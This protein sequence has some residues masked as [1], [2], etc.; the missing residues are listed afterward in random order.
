[1]KQAIKILITL[2]S[3]LS[4]TCISFS[5]SQTTF[6]GTYAGELGYSNSN[7]G[8]N[9]GKVIS[10]GNHNA[11]FGKS[12]GEKTTTGYYNSFY[13]AN[14][15]Y[16][17]T[18]GYSNTFLGYS[19]GYY[20]T[21]GI[22]NLFLGSTTG[23]R[24]TTG[25]SNTFL[26]TYSGV[27][28]T[29]GNCNIYIGAAS[30]YNNLSGSNNVCI[31][32]GSGQN[33]GL[34]SGNVFLGS[35]A[36]QNATGS[37]KLFIANSNTAT[38]L[39]Y[40]EFDSAFVR[41][42]GKLSVGTAAPIGKF[43]VGNQYQVYL[44][45]NICFASTGWKRNMIGFNAVR[46]SNGLWETKGDGAGNGGSVIACEGNGGLHFYSFPST[47]GTTTTH[48]DAEFVSRETFSLDA[49]GNLFIT[50]AIRI[51]NYANS[52]NYRLSVDGKI[53][54]EEIV[55]EM[56]ETWPDYVF[57]SSYKMRS[58][59]DLEIFIKENK[60]LPN[61]PSADEVKEDGI[62]IGEMNKIL[63]EK[64]EENTLYLIELQK[65]NDLLLKRI[66]ELEKR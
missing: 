47:G 56:S 48:T 2:F 37:N 43:Q 49:Y 9:A 3:A 54:A 15:G 55:V 19:T 65:Q 36:G 64:I 24:T 61:V 27:N 12:A 38:P 41:I 42:N 39:I 53:I 16:N 63:L 7:F 22:A 21:S 45:D 10:T 26:G 11:F 34:V 1:M 33:A 57:N 25:S 58:L 6:Y 18:T 23:N 31:G 20:N 50:N 14:S 17:T 51:G 62:G 66:E 46:R 13:G 44:D 35:L 8:Y 60:H 4:V 28:N 59:E 40:G 32:Y 30:G 29:T 52:E 5:Q